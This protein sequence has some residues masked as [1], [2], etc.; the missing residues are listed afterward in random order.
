MQKKRPE[1]LTIIAFIISTI[2]GGNNAIAVRFSNVELPPFFGAGLRFAAASLILFLIVLIMRLPLPNGRSLIGALIFGA[3]QFGFSYALIYW[4]LLEVPAGLFQV[5]L[6]LVPLLTFLLAIAHRQESFQ[7]RVLAGGLLAVGGIAI[8]FSD[9]LID[10]VPLISLLAAVLAA[11]CIAE[12]IVLFKT[13]PKTHP[14]TTNA[15]AMGTGA[16]ILFVTSGF[17]REIPQ[18]PSLLPT[19]TALLYLIFFGSVGTFVLALYVLTRWTASATSYSLVLMPVV[20]VVSASWI[21]DEP[22]TI[23][24][25]LGGLFVLFGVYIG[26]LA[27]PD[28][29]KKFASWVPGVQELNE[30]E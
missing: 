30:P 19:W 26:A 4:S 7:W 10:N 5:I 22:I 29:L 8:I 13:F 23:A 2:L 16:A 15:L 14:I 21:A 1:R 27:P 3:L 9:S 12:S 11:A 28:L 6:A 20:T 18:L 25:L 17:A 24:L